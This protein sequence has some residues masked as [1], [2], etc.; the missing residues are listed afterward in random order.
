LGEQE[1]LAEWCVLLL[2]LS[3]PNE[4]FSSIVSSEN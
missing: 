3:S 1:L 2:L 4:L